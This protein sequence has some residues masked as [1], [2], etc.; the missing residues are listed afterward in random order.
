VPEK[1]EAEKP[2]PKSL[3]RK[4]HLSHHKELRGI[5]SE[6]R[7]SCTT[8]KQGSFTGDDTGPYAQRHHRGERGQKITTNQKKSRGEPTNSN[9]EP[10]LEFKKFMR[11]PQ[12]NV[13]PEKKGRGLG[14]S[15]SRG[16]KC[17]SAFLF[18]EALNWNPGRKKKYRDNNNKG[19]K[20]VSEKNWVKRR[21][22]RRKGKRGEQTQRKGKRSNRLEKG[23]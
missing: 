7:T 20:K 13:T 9:V 5:D 11:R 23:D 14:V 19:D 3:V 16:E 17:Q 6:A 15:E 2:T 12:R 10:K 22:H 18:R 1:N 4:L 8:R 21:G